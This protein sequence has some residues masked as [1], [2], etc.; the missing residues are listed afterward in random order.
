MR[1]GAILTN[2]AN[3]TNL[4]HDIVQI[5][6]D[7][8]QMSRCL[9]HTWVGRVVVDDD[10]VYIGNKL[11]RRRDS[12]HIHIATI[13]Q[14]VLLLLVLVLVLILIL[15][16]VRTTMVLTVEDLAVLFFFLVHVVGIFQRIVAT[17]VVVATG[18]GV[19]VA[20][21]DGIV[22]ATGVGVLQR[23]GNVVVV[24]L[25]FWRCCIVRMSNIA[26]KK[27]LFST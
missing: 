3:Q 10:R 6:L 15:V 4:P 8:R 7:L 20:T 1:A 25:V 14:R 5:V 11:F 21:V 27:S 19:V 17:G 26:G 9:P 16:I 22:V 13:T 23:I 24:G 18:V 12:L 2:S